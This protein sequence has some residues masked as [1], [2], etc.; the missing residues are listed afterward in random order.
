MREELNTSRKGNYKYL[1]IREQKISIKVSEI[2]TT[3]CLQDGLDCTK[4][5]QEIQ[6]NSKMKNIKKVIRK[7]QVRILNTACVWG[8]DLCPATQTRTHPMP[9]PVMRYVVNK[10]ML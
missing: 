7:L 10:V 3:S 1:D 4:Q 8:A 2:S 6:P 5:N 9:L